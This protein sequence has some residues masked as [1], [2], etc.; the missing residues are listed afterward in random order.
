MRT[1]V[2]CSAAALLF[3]LGCGGD[4]PQQPAQ[5]APSAPQSPAAAA[6]TPT[7]SPTPA[8]AA[9]Q[10]TPKK[11]VARPR[12]DY[13]LVKTL[14]GNDPSAPEV[15][16]LKT[17]EA[18][19][20]GKALYHAPLTAAGQ[21]CAS[22]HDLTN[23]GVDAKPTSV[24]GDG[25]RNAPTTW[26][27]FRQFRQTWDGRAAI[28]EDAALAHA[29]IDE[30]KVVAS[31]QG[32]AALV[33][34]F[35]KA[36]AGGSE[37]VTVANTKVALGA[38]L[39]TLATKS[40][41]DAYL[42]GNQKALSNEELVGLSTFLKSNCQTCHMGRLLGGSMYQK[43][44]LLKPYDGKDTGRMQVT[45]SEADKYF[46]K[47]PTLVNIEKTGPYYHDGSMPTLDAAIVHMASVQQNI[48][49]KP[50]DAAAIATFLKATT[51]ELPAEALQK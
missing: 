35:Q 42:D 51:G 8:A 2:L 47:V 16:G 18:I 19:A 46:F 29:G 34:A 36:F 5:P 32:N 50:E 17:P 22:C 20:L 37:V 6:A 21:S 38:F 33:A 30:T 11:P 43:L 9:P 13:E 1:L 41:W 31:I 15:A 28:V 4:K 26:N 27:A 7:A 10:D 24:A 49:L 40:K 14:F 45:Q 25:A 48:T 39:R 3:S 23:Y 44:G 12:I